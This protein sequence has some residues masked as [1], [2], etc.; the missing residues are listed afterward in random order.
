MGEVCKNCSL[1]SG[2]NAIKIQCLI[3]FNI[4]EIA[5]FCKDIFVSETFT[6]HT[7]K[8]VIRGSIEN[9]ENM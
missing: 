5:G 3:G 1:V 7:G 8:Y 2:I 9:A 4:T 6:F